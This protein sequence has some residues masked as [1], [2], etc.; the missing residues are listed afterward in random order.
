MVVID[1]YI[2]DCQQRIKLQEEVIEDPWKVMMDRDHEREEDLI[3][4]QNTRKHMSR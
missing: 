2:R 3:L 1:V 4:F